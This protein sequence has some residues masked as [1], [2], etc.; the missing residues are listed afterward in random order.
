MAGRL[1][2]RKGVWYC[3]GYDAHGSRWRESTKQADRKAAEIVAREIT[4]RR[5]VESTEAP[6]I[7]LK[8]ALVRVG[9]ADARAGRSDATRRILVQKGRQLL[10]F[11]KDDFDIARLTREDLE[12]YADHR[13]K[14]VSRHTI[15]HEI[16]Y[17]RR[18]CRVS[19]VTWVDA[20]MP[21]LGRV[22]VPRERWLTWGEYVKL[23]GALSEERA[24]YL[25]TYCY[26]GA[27]RSELQTIEAFDVDLAANR[28]RIRGTKT[29]GAA[30]WVPLHPSL[31]PVL[32]RR[33]KDRPVGPLFPDWI[34]DIRDL[35]VACARVGIVGVTPN[36][37]RRTFCSWLANAGVS[38]L[39]AARLM[40]HT[41]TRMVERVYA[42]LG[43]EIQSNAVALL[44]GSPS[45]YNSEPESGPQAQEV[46]VEDDENSE[47]FL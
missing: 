40:G 22:Y 8:D 11:F 29:V 19:G 1:F 18:A 38:T 21:D 9:E 23:H 26:T 13:V 2:R 7:G 46:E 14:S 3:W 20:M 12:R 6:R 33:M 24:D 43:V 16:G 27:R 36:D 30:R 45:G 34:N 32:E 31:R 35:G 17:M 25:A 41:S 44:P 42:Q 15:H 5:A 28:V 47:D 37:L 4:R 10:A 39:V